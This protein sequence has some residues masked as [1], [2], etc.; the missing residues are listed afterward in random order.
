MLI[1]KSKTILLVVFSVA[2]IIIISAVVFSIINKNDENNQNTNTE[3]EYN[4][5]SEIS[6]FEVESTENILNKDLSVESKVV[7]LVDASDKKIYSS[8]YESALYYI[9]E[10]KNL[11]GL[12]QQLQDY[13]T[14]KLYQI[15]VAQGDEE[16][17]QE[18]KTMLPADVF[19]SLDNTDPAPPE[20][21]QQ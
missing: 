7:L 14:Y 5:I 21:G 9:K 19:E 12:N 13:L 16:A 18:Y 10:A 11:T 15:S 17:K 3:I 6:E 2:I 20:S 8:D 4:D 1:G